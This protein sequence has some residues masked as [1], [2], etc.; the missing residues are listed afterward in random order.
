MRLRWIAGALA[1]MGLV[2][3]AAPAG[4]QGLNDV[5]NRLLS[6]NCVGLLGTP[7]NP[8]SLGP[9]LQ[10]LC[11]GASGAGN[12]AGGSVGSEGS[13][14]SEEQRQLFRRLRQRQP[15][16]ASADPANPLGI[17]VFVSTEYEKFTQ[18]NT[19]FETGFDRDT[20]GMSFG[21]D[22]LFRNGLILGA[23]FTYG[24]DFG[25]YDGVGGGF[26]HNS[27]GILAYGSV[28]PIAN[29][30][31]DAVAGYTR[32]DYNFDR[33]ASIT[34][35]TLGV[36]GSTHGDTNGNEWRIGVNSGY[37]FV[38]GALTV[39]PR[40]GVL[41]RETTMNDFRESGGT[42]LEL[43]YSNQNIQSLT[44]RPGV[45]GSYAF[46]TSWG[47]V[48]P[49][50]TLE[51]VHEF[52]DDQRSVQFSFVQ[53]TQNRRFLFETTPPDRDYMNL[54]VGV[55]MVLPSGLQ[56]FLNFRDMLAYQDRNSYTVT[57]GLRIPF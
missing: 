1:M 32:R 18:D 6:N 3:V 41:Y 33:R 45:Y 51:Y 20:V 49:Q 24:H 40:L 43:A 12:S 53:D 48:I 27:Y 25:D 28:Q 46:S 36:A 50:M 4:A 47:V 38:F 16:A 52:L 26:D 21:A 57:L 54:G 42:G 30:F 13:A 17:G 56:P 37:D 2:A 8:G 22:Y 19:R 55:S 10:R 34:L 9:D 31:I 29:M 11:V 35:G 14:V 15:G 44:L 7:G 39:G 5:V 23:A